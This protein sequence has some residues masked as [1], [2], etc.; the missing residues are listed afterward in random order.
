MGVDVLG[1]VLKKL[2]FQAGNLTLFQQRIRFLPI[3]AIPQSFLYKHLVDRQLTALLPNLIHIMD[4]Y[5]QQQPKEPPATLPK[6]AT[7]ASSPQ[8]GARTTTMKLR[9]NFPESEDRPPHLAGDFTQDNLLTDSEPRRGS[10]L[11]QGVM[12]AM[13]ARGPATFE[14]EEDDCYPEG[15]TPWFL[16]NNER[17]DSIEHTRSKLGAAVSGKSR[18]QQ[19]RDRKKLRDHKMRRVGGAVDEARHTGDMDDDF[20]EEIEEQTKK[21]TEYNEYLHP[22]MQSVVNAEKL[23]ADHYPDLLRSPHHQQHQMS[24]P[25]PYAAAHIP[26]SSSQYSYSTISDETSDSSM[27]RVDPNPSTLP[28]KS[29]SSSASAAAHAVL[30]ELDKELTALVEGL[31]DFGF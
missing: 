22:L 3:K 18:L 2:A 26:S 21:N 16:D 25:I 10:L 13:A 17:R 5:Q 30:D 20:E 8:T 15:A 9:V 28:D 1:C 7:S 11:L 6:P 29:T 31:G 12:N 23:L 4:Q 14:A 19:Q 24:S 27:D